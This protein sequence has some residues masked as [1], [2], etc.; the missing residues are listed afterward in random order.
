MTMA[1][2]M[3]LA[4]IAVAFCAFLAAMGFKGIL[5][6]LYSICMYVC[7]YAPGG[8]S[9]CLLRIPR[10]D[11][12]QRYSGVLYIT[13]ILYSMPYT[14]H[15]SLYSIHYTLYTI[16]YTLYTIHFL[17]AMGFKGILVYYMP[18]SD[19][20]HL[21][22]SPSLSLAPLL[23]P[24]LPSSSLSTRLPISRIFYTLN[25]TPPLS[26]WFSKDVSTQWAST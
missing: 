25:L 2:I 12:L 20:L 21:S 15:Y 1:W 11:G 3:P 24:P 5:Y 19:D 22:I 8:N 14:L 23:F 6:T 17:A 18:Y 7:M 10:S 16:H 9:R 26:R 13:Y 4:A